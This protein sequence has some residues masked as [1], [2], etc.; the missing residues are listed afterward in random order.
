MLLYLVI[1]IFRTRTVVHTKN[2]D[3]SD[4]IIII[5]DY[6]GDLAVPYDC[7]GIMIKRKEPNAFMGWN[8]IDESFILAQT[9]ANAEADLN[10]ED[11]VP[12]TLKCSDL[13]ITDS[14]FVK[15]HISTDD[16]SAN[17]ITVE[18]LNITDTAFYKDYMYFDYNINRHNPYFGWDISNNTFELAKADINFDIKPAALAVDEIN[19]TTANIT[20]ISNNTLVSEYS[21]ISNLHITNTAFYKDFMYFDYIPNETNPFFGWD[22][23]KDRFF[24]GKTTNYDGF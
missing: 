24:M 13:N 21:E 6:V 14:I 11:L 2:I 3:I 12:A 5:N 22:K 23:H 19:V 7:A 16:M 17:L 1:Y 10:V 8:E 4:N 18:D 20:E 9:T 15:N